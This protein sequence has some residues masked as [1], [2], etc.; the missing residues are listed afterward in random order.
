MTKE[1]IA[2]LTERLSGVIY[3]HEL[4]FIESKKFNNSDKS[5]FLIFSAY[6]VKNRVFQ[7]ITFEPKTNLI[8]VRLHPMFL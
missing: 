7:S 3:F 6:N 1:I 5:L 4:K 8:E 2:K